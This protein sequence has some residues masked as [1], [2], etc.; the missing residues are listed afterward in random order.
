MF[1]HGADSHEWDFLGGGLTTAEWIQCSRMVYNFIKELQEETN[2]QIPLSLCLFG[3][4]RSDDYDSVLS[5]H[6]SDLIECL[7][8]LCGQ[9]INYSP[10]VKARQ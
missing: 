8:I 3:G 7:N 9:N 2:K 10:L 6:T 5:L 4:Y 1:C